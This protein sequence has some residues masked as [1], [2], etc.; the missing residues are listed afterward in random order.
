[1]H[2]RVS[3]TGALIIALLGRLYAF[4]CTLYTRPL[5][6]FGA[7]SGNECSWRTLR[8]PGPA[9]ALAVPPVP[10]DRPSP[11]SAEGVRK[12]SV[13]PGHPQIS[14]PV[15]AQSEKNHENLRLARRY[16]ISHQVFTQPAPFAAIAGVQN[17]RFS[18]VEKSETLPAT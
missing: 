17:S 15:A 5:H 7:V 4:A 13:R 9:F 12:L 2:L 10:A 16:G 8:V 3:R 1:M 18:Y 6:R 14:T 11:A